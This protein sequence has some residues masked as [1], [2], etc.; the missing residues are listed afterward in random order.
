[1][2]LPQVESLRP[3]HS[4]TPSRATGERS[5]FHPNRTRTRTGGPVHGLPQVSPPPG[6]GFLP[7]AITPAGGHSHIR[8][9]GDG[10]PRRKKARD[11]EHPHL[12]DDHRAGRGS[13]LQR[14]AGVRPA[15]SGTGPRGRRRQARRVRRRG[16]RRRHRRA[17]GRRPPRDLPPPDALGAR[18][19][20]RGLPRRSHDRRLTAHPTTPSDDQEPTRPPTDDSQ[21][22]T[23]TGTGHTTAHDEGRDPDAFTVRRPPRG[24][25]PPP[26]PRPARRGRLPA[27]QGE[28]AAPTTQ[29]PDPPRHLTPRRGASGVTGGTAGR[30]RRER[31]F[32]TF[33]TFL[34]F[35][36]SLPVSHS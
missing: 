35:F 17:G 34:F 14:A 24:H 12:A 26:A 36:L 11:V 8:Q 23:A 9:Q 25:R 16:R 19:R 31:V 7:M 1:R 33:F 32:F 21:P 5:T 22:T 15:L 3:G 29:D 6:S 30:Q 4:L 28:A 13:V 2:R 18:R 10:G 20:V 27:R